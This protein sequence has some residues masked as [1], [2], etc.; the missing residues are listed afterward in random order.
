MIFCGKQIDGEGYIPQANWVRRIQ[1]PM[2][3]CR[4]KTTFRRPLVLVVARQSP[5]GHCMKENR[6]SGVC[7]PKRNQIKHRQREREEGRI[8]FGNEDKII[9]NRCQEGTCS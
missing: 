2:K 5:P 4:P 9:K 1:F 3:L 6:Y 8:K 7:L